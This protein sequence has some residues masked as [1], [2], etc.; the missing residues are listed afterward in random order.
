MQDESRFNLAFVLALMFHVLLLGLFALSFSTSDESGRIETD[1]ALQAIIFDAAEIEAQLKSIKEP[2]L[3]ALEKPFSIPE[4]LPPVQPEITPEPEA[5]VPDLIVE[6]KLAQA[7]KEKQA[8]VLAKEQL[9]K[10]NALAEK[11][12]LQE[13]KAAKIQQEDLRLATLKK[14]QLIKAEK[15]KQQKALKAELKKIQRHKEQAETVRLE[16]IKKQHAA[17]AL[18]KRQQ[19]QI[20]KRELAKIRQQKRQKEEKQ[21][22]K[23][24]LALK[25]EQARKLAV[26]KEKEQKEATRLAKIKQ[27]QAK[28][29]AK[30]EKEK[31]EAARL[32]KIKLE[33]T[34]AKEAAKKKKALKAEK[35]RLLAAIKA[36][37]LSR[38]QRL[39]PPQL[40]LPKLSAITANNTAPTLGSQ[41][42]INAALKAAQEARDRREINRLSSEINSKIKRGW[43][44]PIAS[45]QNL[46]C[47]I[48]VQLL[49]DGSVVSA[50]IKRISGDKLF[51]NSALNAV[52]KASPLPVPNDKVL[53][54]K[55]FKQFTFT[56]K[57]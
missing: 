7:A 43:F 42:A 33:Q 41:K 54:E 49:A 51:D 17:V 36:D 39:K 47:M 3:Q 29:A 28:K 23:K 21:R 46:S 25:K 22:K 15:V 20:L 40:K 50:N 11:A 32:A 26:K 52:Y 34:Q 37:A 8:Q 9:I 45:R 24:Q 27:Q 56:F 55:N 5:I 38:Q 16:K 1:N 35:A 30:K 12:R 53:F 13:E 14:Q 44:K 18:E 4:V 6:K 2:T 57:P 10:E 31:K 48:R 19:K